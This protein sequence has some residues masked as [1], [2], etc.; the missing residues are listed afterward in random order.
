MLFIVL[1]IFREILH[2]QGNSLMTYIDTVGQ[3][4]SFLLLFLTK[5]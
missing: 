4:E 1:D 3:V 5:L 2:L